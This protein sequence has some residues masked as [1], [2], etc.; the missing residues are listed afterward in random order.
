MFFINTDISVLEA[1]GNDQEYD[2]K[3]DVLDQVREMFAK[4]YINND[5]FKEPFIRKLRAYQFINNSFTSCFRLL[6]MT[7]FISSV[8]H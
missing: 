8:L 4:V 6:K 1:Y 7:Y 2:I 3:A 5:Y